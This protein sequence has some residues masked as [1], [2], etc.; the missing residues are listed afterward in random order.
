MATHDDLLS[1]Y[2]VVSIATARAILG[3]DGAPVSR[4]TVERM[5]RDAALETRGMGRLRRVTTDSLRRYLTG[6]T[7]WQRS[8]ATKVPAHSGKPKTGNG[9]QKRPATGALFAP[10]LLTARTPGKKQKP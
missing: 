1:A 8:A 3:G 9:G 10:V 2:T 4:D 5:I 6:V 7:T